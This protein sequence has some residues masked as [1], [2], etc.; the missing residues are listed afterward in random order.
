MMK[1]LQGAMLLAAVAVTLTITAVAQQLPGAA[2]VA[3]AGGPSPEEVAAL[4][5]IL[6]AEIKTVQ[7][8]DSR[9]KAIDEFVQKFPKSTLK[10]YALGVAG[11]ANQ[12]KGDSAKALFYYEQAL[13]ADPKDYNS[14]LMISAET[15]QATGEFDLKREEKLGRAEKLAKDSLALIAVAPKPNP[16]VPD[17]QWE[18]VKKDDTARAHEALGMVAMS[19]KNYPGAA[20]E[21]QLAINSASAPPPATYVRMGGALNEAGKY[22]EA[23]AALNKVLA[24]P[25]LPKVIKDVAENEKKRSEQLKSAKK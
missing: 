18:A 20:A 7:D 6:T 2:P 11:E 19:R 21:F 3:P 12:M 15:A 4:Q 16:Q 1:I 22:D 10:A 13:Q 17:A 14:M 9:V 23:L 25:N 5:K 8:V 24:M